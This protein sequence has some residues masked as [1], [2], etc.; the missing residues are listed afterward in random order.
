M[1][2]FVDGSSNVLVRFGLCE[3]AASYRK[4]AEECASQGD[5]CSSRM[6]HFAFATDF[7][8]EKALQDAVWAADANIPQQKVEAFDAALLR[9]VFD[10]KPGPVPGL[11]AG[12]FCDAPERLDPKGK[13]V[14]LF[15]WKGLLF[16]IFF[17]K[18]KQADGAAAAAKRKKSGSDDRSIHAKSPSAF[19]PQTISHF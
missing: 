2:I 6:S 16:F 11:E 4:A 7:H 5:T 18:E 1:T 14:R 3:T 12:Q 15:F 19:V 9:A 13:K 10:L 8:N 17:A